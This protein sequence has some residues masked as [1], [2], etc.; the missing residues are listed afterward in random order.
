MPNINFKQ[1]TL[2]LLLS[3]LFWNCG[4][5][6]TA[7]EKVAVGTIPDK[8][9][10][11][12]T[13]SPP[14]SAVS[15]N[16]ISLPGNFNAY[17]VVEAAGRARQM[18]IRENGDIY[19]QLSK[20]K[21]GKGMVAL[22]DTDG[23]IKADEIVYFGKNTGTGMA[24]YEGHLYCSSPTEVFRYPLKEGTLVPDEAEKTLIVGGFPKQQQHD[25]KS[26]TFDKDGHIYVNVGAP[27]NACMTK[28][29]TKGSPGLDPCPQLDRQAGIWQFDATRPAQTQQ[30]DGLRYAT[31][32][33][34]GMALDWN[35]QTN[36]LYA[37][38]HG[39]DQLATFFPELFTDKESAEFPAEEFFQI[40]KGDDFGWPY[41]FYDGQKNQKLLSPEYGGDRVKTGRCAGMKDPIVAFPGHLAPN[42]LL[43]YTGNQFPER[44]KNGAFIAFHGSWNRAPEPQKGYFVVFVPFKEGQPYGDW[45]IFAEGFAGMELVKSSRDAKHRPMGLAQGPDGALYIADSVKGKIWKVRYSG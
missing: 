8:V 4:M 15:D 44:Y 24:I 10:T 29:R 13:T 45:E 1:I 22:R 19:V 42:D 11:T 16:S 2:L 30:K 20:N 5:E 43:F 35:H 21:K 37:V 26:M 9:A 38:Q 27:S 23:D 12:T 18:A 28:A 36:S 14:I 3:C 6:S 25:A 33:R 34:N 39:R 41:C 17:L 7:K 32:I 40:D 31:G